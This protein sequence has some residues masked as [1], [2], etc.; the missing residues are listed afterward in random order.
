MSVSIAE[1]LV[2]GL[3]A[4]TGIAVTAG[5]LVACLATSKKRKRE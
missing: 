4:A 1:L 3:V 2:L 5:V